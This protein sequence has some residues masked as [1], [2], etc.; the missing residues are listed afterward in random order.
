MNSL[1]RFFITVDTYILYI[2]IF[3]IYI[4]IYNLNYVITHINR[5]HKYGCS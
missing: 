2:I 1:D 4:Y 3:Y 5:V